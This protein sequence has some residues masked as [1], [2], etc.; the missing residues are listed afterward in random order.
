[1]IS[2]S[3]TNNYHHQEHQH[4]ERCSTTDKYRHRH[5]S[6]FLVTS[7]HSSIVTDPVSKTRMKTRQQRLAQ[8][9]AGHPPSP[10]QQLADNPRG[11]RRTRTKKPTAREKPSSSENVK[12]LKSEASL[13]SPASVVRNGQNPGSVPS[14]LQQ[15]LSYRVHSWP[16]REWPRLSCG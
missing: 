15:D 10:P 13:S 9:R 3:I 11:S 4:L 12:D 5:V 2:L 8:E 14:L 6:W 1:M 7:K 16:C